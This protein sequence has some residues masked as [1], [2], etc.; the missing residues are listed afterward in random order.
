MC[1]KAVAAVCWRE[2]IQLR[3]SETTFVDA[4]FS[5]SK[6]PGFSLSRSNDGGLTNSDSGIA[7][8]RDKSANAWRVHGQLDR[9][10]GSW[11]RWRSFLIGRHNGPSIIG[12]GSPFH[13]IR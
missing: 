7:G 2:G 8:N 10:G 4:E 6:G 12:V 3:H 9:A 13:I 11:P 5:N 1:R